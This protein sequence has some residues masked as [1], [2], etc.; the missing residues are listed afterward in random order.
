[1]EY[2]DGAGEQ[3]GVARVEAVL[4]RARDLPVERIAEE[5]LA[6][7]RGHGGSA[8]QED[9]ITVVLVRRAREDGA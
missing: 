2:R 9:D 8:P 6:A 4:R 7:V 1:F 3:F 5:V